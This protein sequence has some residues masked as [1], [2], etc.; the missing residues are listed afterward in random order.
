MKRGRAAA[1]LLVL[2]A[3]SPDK[4]TARGSSS[5]ERPLSAEHVSGLPPDIRRAVE[6]QARACGNEAAARHYFSTSITVGK[7]SFRSLH[8][9]EFECHRPGAVCNASGCL[10]EIYL[11][12][13][14][15]HRKVFSTY[16]GD[17][18][19]TSEG[20]NMI[21]EVT[22]GPSSGTFRWNGSR[23]VS[24]IGNH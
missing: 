8:F 20:G 19:M 17:L 9:E 21:I 6:A 7:L 16:A 14:G 12:S 4:A 13:N 18:R 3:G 1:L 2:I 23:F 5:S 15:H 22:G 24:V 10:H 11:E